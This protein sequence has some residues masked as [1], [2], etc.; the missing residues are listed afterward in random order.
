MT[1]VICKACGEQLGVLDDFDD[2]DTV[3]CDEC[4]SEYRF[5]YSEDSRYPET[6]KM[7]NVYEG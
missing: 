2:G 7:Y 6:L 1:D 4:D 5:A 3:Q